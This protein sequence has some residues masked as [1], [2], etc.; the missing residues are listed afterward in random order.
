VLILERNVYAYNSI[1]DFAG[2]GPTTPNG[3]WHKA[4]VHLEG[5]EQKILPSR[6]ANQVHVTGVTAFQIAQS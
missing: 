4:A 6:N 1:A 3:R 5:Q 2:V